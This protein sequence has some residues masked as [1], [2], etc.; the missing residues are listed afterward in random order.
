MTKAPYHTSLCQT[1]KDDVGEEFIKMSSVPP[2][3]FE[4]GA[5]RGQGNRECGKPHTAGDT[6]VEWGGADRGDSMHRVQRY[7]QGWVDA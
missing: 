2:E 1:N 7:C 6:L 4:L 5:A 3:K